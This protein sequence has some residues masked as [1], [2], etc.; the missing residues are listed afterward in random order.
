MTSLDSTTYIKRDR[1]QVGSIKSTVIPRHKETKHPKIVQEKSREQMKWQGKLLN[2]FLIASVIYTLTFGAPVKRQVCT[3]S[4]DVI[5]DGKRDIV[6]ITDTLCANETP[7]DCSF[8]LNSISVNDTDKYLEALLDLT[9]SN[10]LQMASQA[11]ELCFNSSATD[12]TGAQDCKRATA[13]ARLQAIIKGVI[14]KYSEHGDQSTKYWIE[15]KPAD[16]RNMEQTLC[17]ASEYTKQLL[18]LV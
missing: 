12:C 17:W 13:V 3:S 4:G 7:L 9:Q 2:T 5:K 6:N 1:D 14:A 15:C 16:E 8:D 10:Y 11:V 18:D